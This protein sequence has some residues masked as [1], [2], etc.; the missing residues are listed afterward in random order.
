MALQLIKA[1][2]YELWDYQLYLWLND[3][4]QGFSSPKLFN[5]F[6][7]SMLIG[8]DVVDTLD[9]TLA[10][11]LGF[12]MDFPSVADF[13]TYEE[14][15]HA[16]NLGFSWLDIGWACNNAGLEEFKKKWRAVP[17][18]SVCIQEYHNHKTKENMQNEI[19]S[20]MR[21]SGRMSN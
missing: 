5:V 16:K 18:F 19:A 1:R 14:I 11:P 21:V 17:R 3:Y 13:A 4:I 7:G 10:A 8:F 12:Y 20:L 15:V 2:T 6:L 9:D